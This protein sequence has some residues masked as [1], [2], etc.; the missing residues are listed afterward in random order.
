[1]IQI[2]RGFITPTHECL[3]LNENELILWLYDIFVP[4]ILMSINRMSDFGYDM[5]EPYFL[6]D[7]NNDELGIVHQGNLMSRYNRWQ[8]LSVFNGGVLTFFYSSLKFIDSI[9]TLRGHSDSV[10]DKFLIF[11]FRNIL[12]L[13]YAFLTY[14]I[15]KS[16]LPLREHKYLIYVR[17]TSNIGDIYFEPYSNVKFLDDRQIKQLPLISL[18]TSL[19]MVLNFSFDQACFC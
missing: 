16:M 11:G 5:I 14:F 1:M 2:N 12:S 4:I 15:S 7:M 3:D 13:S 9:S 17:Q 19:F 6:N 10:M 18:T 8:L